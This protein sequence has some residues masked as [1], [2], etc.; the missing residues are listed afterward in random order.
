MKRLV[1][2]DV[3]IIRSVLTGGIVLINRNTQDN[4]VNICIDLSDLSNSSCYT[5]NIGTY[6]FYG[7]KK[8]INGGIV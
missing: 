3:Q 4:I 1:N 6:G 7:F 2:E 5:K 8:S